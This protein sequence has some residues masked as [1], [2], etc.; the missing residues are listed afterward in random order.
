MV[1]IGCRLRADCLTLFAAYRR[2]KQTPFL[3]S[4]HGSDLSLNTFAAGGGDLQDYL[5]RFVANL[6][7]NDAS[8][9]ITWP[10]WTAESPLMLSFNDGAVAQNVTEDT[11]REEAID[12]LNAFLFENPM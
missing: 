3:G 1:S 2:L 7:P 8:T 4:F 10:K 9:N 11:Y 5:I 12:T 6:D